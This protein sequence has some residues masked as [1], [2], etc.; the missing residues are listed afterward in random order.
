MVAGLEEASPQ[1][2]ETWLQFVLLRGGMDDLKREKYKDLQGS[3]ERG[4]S[5]GLC[6]AGGQSE[7]LGG[8]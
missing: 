2:P 8:V 6:P 3:F 4:S 1:G 5:S 7:V